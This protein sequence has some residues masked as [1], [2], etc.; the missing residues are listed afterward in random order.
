MRTIVNSGAPPRGIMP[1]TVRPMTEADLTQVT[2][3]E[4]ECFPT[5]R[6][7]TSFRKELHN[8]LA[9]YLVAVDT[10]RRR[11]PPPP[12]ITPAP[13][14]SGRI[15][16]TLRRLLVGRPV[17]EPVAE[18]RDYL[19]GYVGLW[20]MVDEAHIVAIGVREAYRRHGIGELLLLST[21]ELSRH[22]RACVVTLE[23]RV[24]NAEAQRM[25]EKYGF[26]RVGRRKAY[27]QDNREDAVIMTTD[28]IT[29]EGFQAQFKRLEEEHARRWGVSRRVL[30]P[31]SGDK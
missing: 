29:S 17:K 30:G 5:L 12:D 13:G 15:L 22:M 31:S 2:E 16:A 11:D 26:L 7:F 24:S 27:Y 6:P 10:T 23:V 4:Q 8:K 25:Y 14:S 3:M 19:V 28:D 20:F 1:F 21:I 9:R 18:T